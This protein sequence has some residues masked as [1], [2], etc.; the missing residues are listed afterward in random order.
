MQGRL[1]KT[2]RLSRELEQHASFSGSIR[3]NDLPRL[4]TLVEP[5]DAEIEVSFEFTSAALEHPAI[6]GHY[7][8]RLTAQCQRCL[9]PVGVDLD[10]DFE[11]LIDATDEDVAALQVDTVYS[12]DGLVNVFEV[13]ED[14]LILSLPIIVMH[15]DASCNAYLQSDVADSD[16]ADKNSPF[17]VLAALREK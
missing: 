17:A 8:A 2:Y 10:E 6:A 11:L 15:E 9:E 1:A 4:S 5:D 3:L 14:E 12:T 7:K 13:I 16:S